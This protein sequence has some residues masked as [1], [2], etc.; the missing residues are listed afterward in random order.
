MVLNHR[1]K[2]FYLY[3]IANEKNLKKKLLRQ[4]KK[5]ITKIL[6]LESQVL[7]VDEQSVVDNAMRKI[8]NQLTVLRLIS[9]YIYNLLTFYISWLKWISVK[10]FNCHEIV[11][12]DQENDIYLGKNN[13]YLTDSGI[14]IRENTIPYES[15]LF[16]NRVKNIVFLDLYSK[17]DEKKI[18]LSEDIIHVAI[19]FDKPADFTKKLKNYMYYHIKYNKL[20][21]QILS[22]YCKKIN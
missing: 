13:I 15:V 7:M 9:Y 14:C 6:D 11:L 18:V 22:Y 21:S 19:K 3:K 2:I 1:I 4:Q 8:N 17:L 12:M 20:N 5:S 16:F 10:R